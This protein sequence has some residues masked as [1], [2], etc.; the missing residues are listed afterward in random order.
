VA[1]LR[2][3]AG[4]IEKAILTR[5][6]GVSEPI[7]E[8]D[9]AYVVGLERAVADAVQYGLEGIA[10]GSGS[11][12]PIPP[13]TARQARRAAREGVRLDTVLRRYFA[14]NKT[15][16]E[17]VV[18]AADGVS[19]RVLRQ[20]LSD[21]A[22]HVDRLLESVAAEYRDELEQ[23]R[24]SVRQ[25]QAERVVHF[26]EGDGLVGP[27]GIDYEFDAWHVGT[28]L[29]GQGGETAVHGLEGKVGC[30]SLSVVRDQ[31]TVWAWFGSARRSNI[32]ELTEL[33]G[34]DDGRKVSVAVGEPR[35]GL[36]G[37]R[38]TFREAQAALQVMLYRPQPVTRCRDVILVSAVM[39][40]QWLATSLIETY[41]TPL[42]GKGDSGAVLRRTL[43]AYFERDRNVLSAAAALGVARPTVQRHLRRVEERLGQT[44]G[45]CDA[46]LQVAL[47]VEE[48]LNSSGQ[49]QQQPSA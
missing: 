40:N 9:P 16:E 5:V 34:E 30:R 35:Q 13:E 3:R 23:T 22:P 44:L 10:S 37:W 27:L 20:I 45:T 41:L 24:R 42:D 4:E 49:L 15:L 11:P 14:G 48:L 28:I 12:L 47:G 8:E 1:R 46:Q 18:A 25:K 17:F 7:G 2:A 21:Q 32:A 38:Q 39:R 33:L 19:S 36:D 26:L 6:R 43:R 31:E 29:I